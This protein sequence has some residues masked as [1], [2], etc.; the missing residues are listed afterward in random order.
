MKTL[1]KK[2]FVGITAMA[3]V[4]AIIGV[5]NAQRSWSEPPPDDKKMMAGLSQHPPALLMVGGDTSEKSIRVD[6]SVNISLDCVSQGTIKIN[7]WKRSELRVFIEDG[8]KFGFKVLQKST[9]TGDP[10]WIKVVGVADK[11][12][13]G[14]MGECIW[15]GDIEI[16][17]PLNTTVNIKGK[18]TT[19]TIAAIKRVSII[20]AGGDITLR[21]ITDGVTAYNGQGDITVEA[22]QGAMK[23]DTTTGNIVVFEAGPSEIG[24]IFTAKTNSGS[25]SLQQIEYRQIEAGSLSGSVF[26]AGNILMGGTYTL[27]TTN[28]SIR[29]TLPVTSSCMVDASYGFGNF[30]SEIPIKT[31]TENITPGPVKNIVGQMGKGDA[32]LRVVTSS[33]SI[34]IKKQ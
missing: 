24:D 7:G 5:A 23:L 11:N 21:D 25:I 22:S 13:Y 31:I 16:D 29:L 28:G 27:K 20:T 34:A 32:T 8:S 1:V 9:K 19:T 17:V 10:V 4:A 15:G 33:G 26:Y 30:S 3:V 14:G 6:G 2:L 18:D 12:K